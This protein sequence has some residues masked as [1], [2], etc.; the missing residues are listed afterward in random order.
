MSTVN[1]TTNLILLPVK[2]LILETSTFVLKLSM[3]FKMFL[4]VLADAG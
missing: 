3:K 1:S 4:Y 2:N